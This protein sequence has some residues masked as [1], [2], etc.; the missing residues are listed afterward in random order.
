MA[1]KNSIK[2]FIPDSYYHLYNR[3]VEKRKIFLDRQDY[4]VFLSYL[5][6]YLLP[7]DVLGFQSSLANPKIPW[8]EKDGILKQLRLNNFSDSL[9]LNVYCLMPNHFHLLVHQTEATIID[10]FMNSL[11]TRYVMYFNRKYQRVGP[12]F[13]GLYKAV[14]VSSDEQLLWLTRY[15]HRNPLPLL[16]GS[17]LQSY[18]YSSYPHYLGIKSEEWINSQ[19]ILSFFSKGNF[20]V[21]SYL[22]FIEEKTD[23]AA[24]YE[25]IGPFILEE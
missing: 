24:V 23:E 14:L 22:D 19:D 16:Q 9:R 8:S 2:Q 25:R 13:Q 17:A 7:K 4:L 21:N 6:T 20:G 18:R 1:A 11:W 15:I 5:K 12:L 3:G 10:K